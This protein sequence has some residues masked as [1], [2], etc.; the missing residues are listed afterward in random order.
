MYTIHNCNCIFEKKKKLITK[1]ESVVLNK[2]A[3]IYISRVKF[4]NKSN[5]HT[6]LHNYIFL[7][8]NR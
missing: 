2:H 4:A 6:N 1:L 3:L 8:N 7:C 5:G